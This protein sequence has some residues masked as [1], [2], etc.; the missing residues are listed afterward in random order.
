M[1]LTYDCSWLVRQGRVEEARHS[2]LRLTTTGD[3]SFDA[4]KTIAM[5][6]ET[7]AMEKK[8]SSG[9]SYLDCFKGVDLR[10]TEIACVTWLIQTWCGSTFMGFSTYFYQ[11]A[12]LPT[13]SAFDMSSKY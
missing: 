4:D 5:I 10:R 8:V 7:D 13:T 2:L 1:I 11:Q 3:T 9:T 6:V 12:G